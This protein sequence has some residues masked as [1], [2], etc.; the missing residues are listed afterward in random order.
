MAGNCSCN[1]RFGRT[2][3][4]GVR[5]RSRS[6]YT[7][8]RRSRDQQHAGLVARWHP[9]RIEHTG[10]GWSGQRW[11]IKHVDGSRPDEELM[12]NF[13]NVRIATDWSADGQS[14]IFKQ[15]DAVTGTWDLWRCPCRAIACRSKLRARR[16]TSGTGSSHPMGSRWRSS[17]TNR[18]HGKFTSNH[19]LG[20]GRKC[21]SPRTAAGKSGGVGTAPSFFTWRSTA[22]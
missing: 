18:D 19:S 6:V 13:P 7:A 11:E 2:S 22:C 15:Q 16:T 3:M 12:P 4:Y 1:R 14:V 17:R 5:P 21:G 10:R 9:V 8:H 20:P